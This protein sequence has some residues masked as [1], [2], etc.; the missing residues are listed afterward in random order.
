MQR[1]H[2]DC[3]QKQDPGRRDTWKPRKKKSLRKKEGRKE[4]R[5]KKGR[6]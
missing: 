4:G 1:F 2:T 3:G 5:K 6:G